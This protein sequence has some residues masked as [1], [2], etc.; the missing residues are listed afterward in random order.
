MAAF[1]RRMLWSCMETR[2]ARNVDKWQR[3][4]RPEP[5]P[6]IGPRTLLPRTH[7]AL[8]YEIGSFM[9]G[10]SYKTFAIIEQAYPETDDAEGTLRGKKPV[11]VRNRESMARITD[12]IGLFIA[13]KAVCAT[14]SQY[15]RVNMSSVLRHWVPTDYTVVDCRRKRRKE[16]IVRHLGISWANTKHCC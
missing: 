2:P 6:V 10:K 15:G 7:P 16:N 12:H 9:P 4:W 1:I 3:I 5:K 14:Q 8:A 11:Q 13:L